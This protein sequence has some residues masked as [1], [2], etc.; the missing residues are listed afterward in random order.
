[1]VHYG[2]SEITHLRVLIKGCHLERVNVVDVIVLF[3]NTNEWLLSLLC[4]C[5]QCAM[6]SSGIEV[7]SIC[8]S[9]KTHEIHYI[10]SIVNVINP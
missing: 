5:R 9:I 10:I 1:M 6:D 4:D 2:V 8:L 3:V 7:T